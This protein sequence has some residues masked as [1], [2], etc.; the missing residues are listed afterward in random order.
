MIFHTFMFSDK[1]G[2]ENNE[3]FCD[4]YLDEGKFGIWALSDGL[5]GQSGGEIASKIAAETV[6]KGFLKIPE[7]SVENISAI[8]KM[9]NFNI[10]EEQKKNRYISDM[11]ATFVGLFTD[12]QNVL[13]CHVGD[14]RLYYF[15]NKKIAYQTMDHSLSQLAVLKGEITKEEIRFHEDRN[16]L[17]RALGTSENLK[18]G[19]L[20]KIQAI[21]PGDAFLI[22]S[23]GFWEYVLEEE[24]ETDLKNAIAPKMWFEL[25]RHRLLKRITPGYDNYSAICIIVEQ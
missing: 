18:L 17:L 23:D 24:M 10:L 20:E 9:S 1:G 8:V 4:F 15:K 12:Y 14:S 19:G 6:I 25:M 13:W 7:F 11:G 22:C 16:R 5:G 21:E 2:R 3:D